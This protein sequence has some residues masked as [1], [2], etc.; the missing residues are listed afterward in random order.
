MSISARA[1]HPETDGA[2]ACGKK[3]LARLPLRA[4]AFIVTLYGDVVEPRGGRLWMGNIVEACEAV[5]ISETLVRTAVSRLV[6]AGQLLGERQGRR[7][8]YRLT[9]AARAD[10]AAASKILFAAPEKPGWRFVWLDPEAA[11]G[12]A[13]ALGQALEQAGFARL[14]AHWFLGPADRILDEPALAAFAVETAAPGP[15]LRRLAAAHWPLA[16]TAAAYEDF[17]ATFAPLRSWREAGAVGGADALTLRLLLV[18]GYRGVALRDAR[19]PAAA[20][21]TDWSGHRARGF[22]ADLYRA[23]S[24]AAD[25][26]VAGRFLSETGTLPQETPLTARRLAALA[27][28]G[29]TP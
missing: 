29:S 1:N 27:R 25:A 23:L 16:A 20:L 4:G 5:G 28:A 6:A 21:P 8:F 9:D 12:R 7:S 15:S 10:Y 3:I 17:L 18:H 19:L 2:A 26:E 14:G 24:P 11:G 13:P 22:F